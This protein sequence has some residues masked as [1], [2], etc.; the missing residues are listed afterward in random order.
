MKLNTLTNNITQLLTAV[1]ITGIAFSA[2]NLP[3]KAQNEVCPNRESIEVER[4][5]LEDIVATA[6]EMKAKA[7]K[8][9]NQANA[10]KVV[11]TLEEEI[12]TNQARIDFLN[13]CESQL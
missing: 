6:E 4:K 9:S 8:L 3:G 12:A 10:K 13:Q 7:P 1:A 5:Q 11:A 2:S